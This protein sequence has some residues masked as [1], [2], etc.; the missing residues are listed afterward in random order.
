MSKEGF[1]FLHRKL[2]EWEWYSN[3]NVTR[4]FIHCLLEANHQDNNWQGILVKKGS[5]ITSYEKLALST[6]LTTQQVRTAIDKL[7]ITGE[8]TYKSTSRYSMI[9]INNWNCYQANQQTNNKQ[10]T[11]KQQTN[12]KQITTN[13]NDNNEE[14]EENE[15]KYINESENFSK[16]L[17]PFSSKEVSDVIQ[18][19]KKTC[20]NLIPYG[21]GS[22]KSRESIAQFIEDIG[23]DFMYIEMVFEKANSLKKICDQ[24][25]DLQKIIN[26][27]ERIANDYYKKLNENAKPQQQEQEEID[28]SD[29]TNYNPNR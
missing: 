20:T 10:I 21:K 11:S 2:T 13:N 19:Y 26:C 6:S 12:N 8:I 28:Y 5:F 3:V 23:F 15:N 1:I 9:T 24:P 29:Y 17:D 4:I 14:N 27:H 7:K 18:L 25:I 16:K 22:R